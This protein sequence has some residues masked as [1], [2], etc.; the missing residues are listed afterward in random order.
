MTLS[1]LRQDAHPF[2][3]CS[4][5]YQKGGNF[6]QS[7]TRTG[8]LDSPDPSEVS[9]ESTMQHEESQ[10]QVDIEDQPEETQK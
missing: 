7:E 9:V 5:D 6:G 10:E 3:H 2:A 1:S 8:R 4:S